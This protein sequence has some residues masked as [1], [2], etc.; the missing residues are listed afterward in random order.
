MCIALTAGIF[1]VTW[2]IKI[3]SGVY[4]AEYVKREARTNENVFTCYYK[5]VA[6]V[7]EHLIPFVGSEN[8][9]HRLKSRVQEFNWSWVETI[10]HHSDC[11]V[12][13]PSYYVL[14]NIVESW[15]VFGTISVLVKS[16][17]QNCTTNIK[18]AN[19]K[20]A[21][22]RQ[23]RETENLRVIKKPRRHRHMK[24]REMVENPAGN[25]QI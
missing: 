12:L 11:F 25:L 20:I 10:N 7:S 5:S 1:A 22:L 18:H 14:D 9:L 17:Y 23:T 13:V 3:C 2:S 6:D 8:Y 15:L 19:R 16:P 21:Q 4:L 24:T